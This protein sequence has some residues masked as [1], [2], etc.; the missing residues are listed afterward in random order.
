VDVVNLTGE[1]VA[2][3][4]FSVELHVSVSFHEADEVGF[5]VHA[6]SLDFSVS[7]GLAGLEAEDELADPPLPLPVHFPPE[8]RV[9]STQSFWSLTGTV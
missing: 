9:T 7:V 6:G 1:V 8:D 5:P 4:G 3:E 2:D